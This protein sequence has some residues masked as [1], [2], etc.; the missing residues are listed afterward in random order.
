MQCM[1][2]RAVASSGHPGG[3]AVL[4]LYFPM[5]F[6]YFPV[7]S[8]AVLAILTALTTE[9][10]VTW[11][12]PQLS[13]ATWHRAHRVA[14]WAHRAAAWAHRAAAWVHRAAAGRRHRVRHSAQRAAQRGGGG[15]GARLSVRLEAEQLH[16]LPAAQPHARHLVRV[17]VRARV[18]VR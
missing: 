1:G 8:Q 9:E 18:R 7:C 2:C 15:G 13:S 3:E 12:A 14:A 17:R 10:R 6:L 11:V 16:V 5:C 4:P